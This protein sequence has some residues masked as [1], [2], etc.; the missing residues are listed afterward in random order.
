MPYLEA[1][2]LGLAGLAVSCF[3]ANMHR[4]KGLFYDGLQVTLHLL[5]NILHR[6]CQ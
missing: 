3:C 2:L 6:V 5:P 4:T 1:S